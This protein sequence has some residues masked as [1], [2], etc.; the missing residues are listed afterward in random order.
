MLTQFFRV[1]VYGRSAR[2]V[3]TLEF[4]VIGRV[5]QR[6]GKEHIL[7]P[8]RLSQSLAASLAENHRKDEQNGES[9]DGHSTRD[10]GARAGTTRVG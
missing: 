5:D 6:R 1:V 2:V 4:I 10:H 7:G 3:V 8:C 9:Q